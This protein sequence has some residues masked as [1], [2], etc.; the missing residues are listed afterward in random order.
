MME[1]QIAK[2]LEAL[3]R[4]GVILYPTDTVWGIGCDATNTTA[5]EKVLKIKQSEGKNGLI[6]LMS[7]ADMAARY[8]NDAPAVAW[9]LLEV[10]DKPLT[11]I[12]P[13]GCGVAPELLGTDGTIAVRIPEHEFCHRL[14]H[15]LRRPLVS[16]S[17][18]VSGKPAPLGFADISPEITSAVD[19]IVAPSCQG[20]PSGKPSAIIQL[21]K[22]GEIKIIR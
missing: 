6:T 18:N 7:S 2:A 17:A 20:K 12:L 19:Y 5:V 22:G 4:G 3:Q 8:V 11:L 21:G 16:T 14:L 1:E 10:A 9:E 13:G 15:R